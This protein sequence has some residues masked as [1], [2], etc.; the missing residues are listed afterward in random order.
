MLHGFSPAAKR[1]FLSGGP[2][3]G[4][5]VIFERGDGQESSYG[6]ILRCVW[7]LG[8]GSASD[9]NNPTVHEISITSLPFTDGVSPRESL[10]QSCA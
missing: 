2:P 9:D 4:L 6:P 8:L 5:V 3:C 10:V 7:P 1:S